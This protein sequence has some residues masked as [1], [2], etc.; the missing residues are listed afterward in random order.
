MATKEEVYREVVGWPGYYVSNLGNIKSDRGPIKPFL[1]HHGYLCFNVVRTRDDRKLVRV[2]REVLIA[3]CGPPP[4]GKPL[5][6]HLDGNPANCAL[7]NLSWGSYKDNEADK[8]RHGRSLDGESNHAAKLTQQQ[9]DEIRTSP[10]S[11]ACFAKRF[12]VAF[13]TVW[14]VR[15]GRSWRHAG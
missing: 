13:Q 8:R 4:D 14:C 11:I 1:N 3:F 5:G 7:D 6:R 10:E 2:H 12:G 9:V 15:T